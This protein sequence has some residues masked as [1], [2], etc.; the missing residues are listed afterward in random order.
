MQ[1]RLLLKVGIVS[2]FGDLIGRSRL[3]NAD[4]SR[5]GTACQS[6]VRSMTALRHM[7]AHT[8]TYYTNTH[9]VL[10]RGHGAR[11]AHTTTS[12][13]ELKTLLKQLKKQHTHAHPPLATSKKQET[14]F[15]CYENLGSRDHERAKHSFYSISIH[16][17]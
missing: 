13:E 12:W 11:S 4:Y 2:S 14:A 1:P 8:H 17:L 5:P 16:L 7:Q 10:Y 6:W 9:P 15:I 3:F